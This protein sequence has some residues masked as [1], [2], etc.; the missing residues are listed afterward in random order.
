MEPGTLIILIIIGILA[1]ILSGFVGVG[2]GMIIVP[3]LIYFMGFT[4]FQAQGTSLAMMLPPIGIL[5]V[6]NYHKSG[7]V[8]ITYALIIA[9]TFIIGGFFGS[10][11][12]LKLPE[13]KVKLIFGLIMLYAAIRMIWKSIGN[14]TANAGS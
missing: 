9:V 2:G 14:M 4:Q 6:M 1:G 11:L 7:N 13:N 12:A 5:A 3:A 8:N 10:K